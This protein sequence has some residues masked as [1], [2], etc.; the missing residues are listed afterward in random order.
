MKAWIRG[1]EG[2]QGAVKL[3]LASLA[4]FLILETIQKI[5]FFCHLLASHSLR[6]IAGETSMGGEG[7][8]GRV[9]RGRGGAL[10]AR[11]GEVRPGPCRARRGGGCPGQLK[12]AHF[13][14][15]HDQLRW[16]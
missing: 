9:V 6:D 10:P 8:G 3:L 4:D 14:L 15:G 1:G 2:R 16:G 11:G 7:G 12:Q 5:Y 13:R